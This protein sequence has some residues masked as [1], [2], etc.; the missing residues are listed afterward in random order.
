[1]FF[2]MVASPF[3]FVFPEYPT[4]FFCLSHLFWI[5][6]GSG[7]YFPERFAGSGLGKL[8]PLCRLQGIADRWKADAV[9]MY[10][11]AAVKMQ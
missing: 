3:Y 10:N 6:A 11:K 7:A 5:T 4:A 1:M 9:S 2:N 8:A